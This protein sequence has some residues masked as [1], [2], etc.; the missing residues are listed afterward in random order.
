MTTTP[1]RLGWRVT[2]LYGLGGIANGIKSV[3]FGLFTLF[4]YT[5]VLGLPGTLV[6][7]ASMVGV[8][9]DSVID[10]FIGY[11]SDSTRGRFGNRHTFLL[12]G[13]STMGVSFW[14]LFAPPRGLSTIGLFAWLLIT[15]LCLRT[16]HSL[17][18]VP[19][20]AL[21][22]ELSDDYHER[23]SIVG[24]RG[25]L[26][27]LGTLAAA[28][29]SFVVFFPDA[30]SG[31]DPKLDSGRYSAM[32]LAMGVAMMTTGLVATAGTWPW[33]ARSGGTG[34]ALTMRTLR[35]FYGAL[36]QSLRNRSFRAVLFSISL[37]FLG[38]VINSSLAIHYL[39]YYARITTSTSLS[40][41][42]FTFYASALLGVLMWLKLSRV[43]EK[44]LLYFAGTL[45]TAVLMFLAYF[46]IGEGHLFGIGNARV[47]MIGNGVAGLLASVVWIM[48]ASMV[49][50][51]ADQSELSTGQSRRGALFGLFS[52]GEQLASGISLLLIG[53]LVDRFA[54]LVPGQMQQSPVTIRRVG[55]L[56]GVLPACLLVVAAAVS[57]GYALNRQRVQTIQ[58]RLGLAEGGDRPSP[59][60][61]AC[62]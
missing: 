16:S 38:V 3:V 26:A 49:A 4:F 8:I 44:R 51:V 13:A 12:I 59:P 15:N 1:G 14:A 10:P 5:T 45:L 31:A 36:V 11:L 53:V 29:S 17:F 21:G 33:R 41:I 62:D 57:L 60:P 46:L 2:V 7:V 25:L 37:F 43:V 42:Q 9:W 6:G 22:A 50:D 18:N 48:P 56:Y 32:G 27:L 34:G 39:T 28:A 61:D 19:Y 35:G 47:L 58:R 30:S 24:I 40:A 55:L 20:L 23:T 54:G 52:F